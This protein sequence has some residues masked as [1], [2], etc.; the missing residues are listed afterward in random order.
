[1]A[2]YNASQF[3][4]EA[5]ASI[6]G[7]THRD[8]ELIVIEDASSDNSLAVLQSFADKRIRIIRHSA[9]MGAAVSRNDGMAAACGEFIA[10]MDADDVSMPTR[11][12]RQ[13][14]F[15]DAHPQVGLVGCGIY[16]N[17]DSSGMVL[18]T[19][20]LPKDNDSIQ[21]ALLKRWCFV[22]S[23]IMFRKSAQES[24]GG[25]RTTFEPAEDHD[26]ILRMLEHTQAHSLDERLVSYRL[27]PNGLSVRGHQYINE[28]GT[29]AIRMAKLRRAGQPEDL[30]LEMPRILALK[31]RRKAPRGLAGIMQLW[32][33]SLYAANRYYGLGCRELCA[34][35]MKR[36]RNCFVRSLLTN[37][38]FVKAWLGLALSHIPFVANRVRF[39]FR[40]S[41]QR[42]DNPTGSRPVIK[43]DIYPIR[44][45][46]Q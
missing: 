21:Q 11:L 39:I 37:G 33:D 9:N 34:G 3:L 10:I 32:R 38:W 29:V 46:M 6:L 22:H 18:S 35:H 2:V 28:L 1:M 17:I 36:A 20:I 27:N 31:Q 8:F 15:F 23:S 13:V 41:W 12:E 24:I 26:F 4:R 30:K 19:S 16:D 44:E 43:P 42:R 25:Y 5:V 7:Q 45:T 40:S 14:A